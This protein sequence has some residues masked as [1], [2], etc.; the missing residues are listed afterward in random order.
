MMFLIRAAF[1]LTIVLIL[2]PA[3]PDSGADAPR[4]T[5]FRALSAVRA[6]VLDLSRFCDRNPDVCTTGSDVAVLVGS[7]ARYATEQIEGY[8]GRDQSAPAPGEAA[9]TLTA[10]DR[11]APWQDPADD[12]QRRPSI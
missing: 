12:D 10:A 11:Q 8:L 6:T 3:D 1:W 7:K 2:L 4:V 5:V 9:G